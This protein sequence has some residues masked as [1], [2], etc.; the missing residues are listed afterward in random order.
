MPK[1]I[2]KIAGIACGVLLFSVLLILFG[3]M[4]AA[5]HVVRSYYLST[6]GTTGSCVSADQD[7][8]FD[9]ESFCSDDVNRSLDVMQRANAAL[10]R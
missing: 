4:C 9:Q 1:D 10:K 2:L 8:A 3:Q 5:D 7:W 6:H